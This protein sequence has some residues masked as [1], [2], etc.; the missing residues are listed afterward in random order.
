MPVNASPPVTTKSVSKSLSGQ[1]GEQALVLLQTGLR[2]HC[3]LN[4]IRHFTRLS[5]KGS[6]TKIKKKPVFIQ[7]HVHNSSFQYISAGK[8]IRSDIKHVAYAGGY[9]KIIFLC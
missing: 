4:T 1:D 7:P 9:E 5:P 8:A 2:L 6:K 3:V